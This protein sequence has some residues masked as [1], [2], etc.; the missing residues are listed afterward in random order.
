[1]GARKVQS[2]LPVLGEIPWGTHLC[3]FYERPEDLLETLVPYFKAGL[4]GNEICVWV[5]DHELPVGAAAEALRAAL[6]DL[7]TRLTS[8]QIEI[9]HSYDWYGKSVQFNADAVLAAWIA[10]KE[11]A[12][13]RGFQGVR[14]SGSAFWLHEP[15]DFPTFSNYE[16]RLNQAIKSQPI[17]CLCS[18]A[19][20]QAHAIE[21]LDVVSNHEIAITRRGGQWEILEAAALKAAK[22]E[23]R[24]ANEMLEL[25]VLERT[26]E[27]ERLL[28]SERAA[29]E[30]AETEAARSTLLFAQ[31]QEAIR[32][33]DEFLSIASHELNTPIHSLQLAVHAA[34]GDAAPLGP[35]E[36]ARTLKLV[37]R[38]SKRL[39]GLVDALLDASR[40]ATGRL[41]LHLESVNLVH[42][43]KEMVEQ[44]SEEL[45]RAQC[46]LAMRVPDQPVLGRWDRLRLEQVVANLLS[47]AAKFGQGKPVQIAVEQ[48]ADTARLVVEDHGIGIPPEYR[49]HIFERFERAVSP[50]QYGGLGLGLYI[51]RAIVEAMGGT[52]RA[53]STVGAG[54]SFV[55]EL[56]RGQPDQT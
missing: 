45:A 43:V 34:S 9:V 14:F 54:A 8:G 15:H 52:V 47:N 49:S 20:R 51:V 55:V 38:Q 5:T 22:E 30:A 21:L 11:S 26:A 12:V 2:G 6:P 41:A 40:I 27:I 18:Y 42:V 37:G 13:S 24:R 17:I 56:P 50:R 35:D 1:M 4:E 36:M 44:L 16:E 10:K 7:D 53:Q 28:L 46:K 32:V 48:T 23:L 19:L 3:Q 39:G 33:R 29:R 31:A 25:K